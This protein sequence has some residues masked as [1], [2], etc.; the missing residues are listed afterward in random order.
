MKG[1][2]VSHGPPEVSRRDTFFTQQTIELVMAPFLRV[3]GKIRLREIM[4]TG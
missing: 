3:I 1:Y 2:V 4:E